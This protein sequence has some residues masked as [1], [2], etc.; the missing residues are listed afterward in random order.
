[1]KNSQRRLICAGVVACCLLPMATHAGAQAVD[2]G[3]PRQ[4]SEPV[5]PS[6]RS[7][8][9]LRPRFV[10]GQSHKFSMTLDSKG[11]QSVPGL[12]EQTQNI[13]Q[14][15]GL[16]LRVKEVNAQTGSTLEMVYDS[17]KLR[18]SQADGEEIVFDS[19]KKDP[20]DPIAM[21]L[22][23]IVG[24][25]ITIKADRDG[26]ITNVDA[27]GAMGGALGGLSGLAG[28]S[29]ATGGADVIKNLL[30]PI[31]SLKPGTPEA[32]VGEAWTNDDIIDAPWG[33]LRLT[34]TNTL[35]SHRA[36]KATIDI[37]GQFSLQPSSASGPAPA[38]KDSGLSGSAVWNTESGMLESLDFRQRMTV[39]SSAHGNSAQDMS[40]KVRTR[41]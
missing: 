31:V 3:R 33:K 4:A 20:N 9:N 17:L 27:G 24:T 12:G 29:G 5:S 40:V 23:S 10:V 7:K 36:S 19:T 1:M 21:V 34:T 6:T 39:E 11:R 32:A 16:T 28:G 37:K 15:I 14:E 38:I 30:G 2:P 26:N 22:S 41:R 25:T 35:T 8:V 18:I 13:S